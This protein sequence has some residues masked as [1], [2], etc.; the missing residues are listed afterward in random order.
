MLTRLTRRLLPQRPPPLQDPRLN[1]SVQV[2]T[3]CMQ[4]DCAD[5]MKQFFRDLRER[6]KKY[7]PKEQ[8]E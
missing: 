3:G 5:L 8:Q 2:E 6:N 1:H 4:Q 7:K